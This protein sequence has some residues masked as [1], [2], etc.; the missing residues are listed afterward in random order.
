MINLFI[1]LLL[2]SVSSLALFAMHNSENDLTK[3]W[4]G[5]VSIFYSLVALWK[6]VL[7]GVWLVKYLF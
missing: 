2:Y 7:F 6:I 1:A 3:I 4:L 5:L